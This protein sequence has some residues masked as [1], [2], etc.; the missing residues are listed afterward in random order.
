[1]GRR[2]E[3]VPQRARWSTQVLP[4]QPFRR[5]DR[6]VRQDA[7]PVAWQGETRRDPSQQLC[8]LRVE[9]RHSTAS[10]RVV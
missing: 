2:V 3:K 6:V 1:M 4:L 10:S 7:L 9:V 5:R 8:V